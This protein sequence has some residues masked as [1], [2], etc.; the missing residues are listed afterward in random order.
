[1]GMM[2]VIVDEGLLDSSFIEQRCEN[3]AA[4]KDS[5]SNLDLESVERITDTPGGLV[6]EATRWH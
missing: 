4:F 2:R 5:L 6:A 1:M 3:F